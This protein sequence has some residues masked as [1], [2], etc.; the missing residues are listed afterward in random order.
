MFKVGGE[1]LYFLLLVLIVLSNPIPDDIYKQPR[2]SET[3]L[4]EG[5]ELTPEQG[6]FGGLVL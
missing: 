4:E 3:L 1:I 5:L 2:V 6:I